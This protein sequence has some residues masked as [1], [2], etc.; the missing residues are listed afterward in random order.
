MNANQKSQVNSLPGNGYCCDCNSSC[1]AWASLTYGILICFECAGRHRGLGV[2]ISFVRSLTLDK[3]NQDQLDTMMAGGNKK[4]TSFLADHGTDQDNKTTIRIK[5]ATRAVQLYKEILKAR[6]AGKP[7]PKMSDI[8]S[9]DADF[10]SSPRRSRHVLDVLRPSV[11]P[12]SSAII[13]CSFK[14]WSHT[15]FRPLLLDKPRPKFALY[16]VYFGGG[17]VAYSNAELRNNSHFLRLATVLTVPV[18]LA[19]GYILFLSLRSIKWWKTQRLCAF[20]SAKNKLKERIMKGRAKQNPLYDLYFPP[21]VSIGSIVEKAVLFYPE[22]LV[23]H[24]SYASIVGKLSDAGILIVVVNLEPLR[25]PIWSDGAGKENRDKIMFEVGKLLGIEVKEW[26]FGGH[27]EGGVAALELLRSTTTISRGVFWGCSIS[28]SSQIINKST[29]L[30]I[31]ATN[32]QV[33]RH[34]I[35]IKEQT[36]SKSFFNIEGGNHSGFAHY[37]PQIF[38]RKDGERAITIDEQQKQCVEQTLNFVF[39]REIG[40]NKKD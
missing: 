24:V 13:I 17:I 21:N 25:T 36:R 39:G 7:E 2:H 40:K 11:L 14:Y 12:T 30:M 37:G 26:I 19:T 28:H 31:N 1:P 34:T 4:F 5:Y 9:L 20:K 33:A 27:G 38:P 10:P 35:S 8:P 18:F 6:V 16:A 29:T 23:D 22:L 3:W 32:D 15:L